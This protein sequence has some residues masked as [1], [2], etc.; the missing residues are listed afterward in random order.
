MQDPISKIAK[1]RRLEVWLKWY[2]ACLSSTLIPSPKKASIENDRNGIVYI[3]Y[4]N[5][6]RL[7]K[8]IVLIG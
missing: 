8:Q 2:S 3:N 5:R 7:K 4:G 6:E 1:E